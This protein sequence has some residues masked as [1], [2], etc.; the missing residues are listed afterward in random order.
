VARQIGE[1]SRRTFFARVFSALAAVVASRFVFAQVNASPVPL[2]ERRWYDAADS[3]KRL[4]ESW[5]DQPF[6]AVLVLDGE[7]VG[8]GPSRVVQLGDA[9]AHAEREAIKDAQRHLNRK[10]LSG[11]VLYS[12]S[13]PCRICEA[14][15]AAAEVRQMYY[16][17]MLHDAGSPRP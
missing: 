10:V 8:E 7:L 3:M 16:G 4:A 12:T 1:T 5:G 15:A 14:A 6:G 13:R 11:S 9:N 2:P 17:S